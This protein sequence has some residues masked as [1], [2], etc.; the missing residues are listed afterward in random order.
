MVKGAIMVEPTE[1]EP[2]R[3][4]ERFA[5]AIAAIVQEAQENPDIVKSAPHSTVVARVDEVRA[6]RDLDLRY[7]AESQ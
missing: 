7:T 6:A 2:V 4:L 5:D 3:E 1:T